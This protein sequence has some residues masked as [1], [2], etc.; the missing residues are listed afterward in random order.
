V[1]GSTEGGGVDGDVVVTAG[2][3]ADGA[4]T[5]PAVD[6]I[7]G[8]IVGETDGI[9]GVSG[10]AGG[11][12]SCGVTVTCGSGTELAD[13]SAVAMIVVGSAGLG[14]PSSARAGLATNA[15]TAPHTERPRANEVLRDMIQEDMYPP[16]RRRIRKN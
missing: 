6:G 13:A 14:T 9:T 16:T 4:S 7:A 10:T 2:D 3:G 5:S 15:A 12:G 11:G 1:E 8:G